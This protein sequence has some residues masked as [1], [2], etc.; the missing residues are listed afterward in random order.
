MWA[1]GAA[2]VKDPSGQ[3]TSYRVRPIETV[4]S[5]RLYDIGIR[6]GCDSGESRFHDDSSSEP[7][8]IVSYH[9][10]KSS[11]IARRKPILIPFGVL[12]IPQ[13]VNVITNP[14]YSK[15]ILGT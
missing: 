5:V 14:S 6:D 13:Y 8:S 9:A 11:I 12:D 4:Q 15:P 10:W 7:V 3:E 1:D 2:P